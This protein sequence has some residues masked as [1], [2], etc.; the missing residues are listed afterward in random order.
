MK[1]IGNNH[2][3]VIEMGFIPIFDRCFP[4]IT[5]KI[6]LKRVDNSSIY[7]IISLPKERRKTK[8]DYIICLLCVVIIFILRFMVGWITHKCTYGEISDEEVF[9]LDKKGKNKNGRN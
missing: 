2:K 7:V 6:F 4:Y 5:K 8:M 3:D 1:K 9:G